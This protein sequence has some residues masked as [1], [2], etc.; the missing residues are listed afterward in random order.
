MS[1]YHLPNR[2]LPQELLDV[3]FS[4][5][6]YCPTGVRIIQRKSVEPAWY[7]CTAI[8][9][10][11][12]HPDFSVVRLD[13]GGNLATGLFFVSRKHRRAALDNFFR[14]NVF[15]FDVAPGEALEFL[16]SLGPR[17]Q[18]QIRHVHIGYKC[19]AVPKPYHG[20]RSRFRMENAKFLADNKTFVKA[21]L[22]WRTLD[23]LTLTVTDDDIFSG[24]ERTS[25]RDLCLSDSPT[26]NYA[27]TALLSGGGRVRKVRF[28]YPR[29]YRLSWHS[30]LFVTT[31]YYLRNAFIVNKKLLQRLAVRK[32]QLVQELL[33]AEH[34]AGGNAYGDRVEE[35]CARD[36][37]KMY[38]QAGFH[39][40]HDRRRLGEMGTVVAIVRAEEA[41]RSLELYR[42]GNEIGGELAYSGIRI[43]KAEDVVET[44]ETA[45]RNDRFR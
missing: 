11:L 36:L 24:A 40:Y 26:V 41:E 25:Q 21:L 33:S 14:N 20:D 5:A 12:G 6:L 42:R 4:F 37:H 30:A 10:W 7:C 15:V 13:T 8:T 31:A 35:M 45:G 9:R 28:A 38:R 34:V 2:G 23:T 19:M 1:A 44:A 39:L 22:G 3:I 16:C 27:L 43:G 17:S 29:W 18:Q 32:A